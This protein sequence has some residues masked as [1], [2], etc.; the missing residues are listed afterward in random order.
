M[1]AGRPNPQ[2]WESSPPIRDLIRRRRLLL[3]HDLHQLVGR[4]RSQPLVGPDVD[5]SANPM[6]DF[7]SKPHEKLRFSRSRWVSNV[8]SLH[9]PI[10]F[11]SLERPCGCR[12]VLFRH[13]FG[14]ALA[15]RIHARLRIP[16][17]ELRFP[18]LAHGEGPTNAV[19]VMRGVLLIAEN[20]AIPVV[21]KYDV[22]AVAAVV[23]LV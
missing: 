1:L 17:N 12:D 20:E 18:L 6:I 7:R 15:L 19:T 4:A 11:E 13:N 14:N 16:C 2:R 5:R 23:V 3:F 10:D 22:A 8:E 21:V 9:L